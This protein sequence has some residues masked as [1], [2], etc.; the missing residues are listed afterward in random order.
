MIHMKKAFAT[1]MWSLAVVARSYGMLLA[2]AVFVA[3]WAFAAYAWLGLPESSGLLL[4][5]ALIWAIVQL[6]A[7]VVIICGSVSAA[8]EVAA[9]DGRQLPLRLL[10]VKDRAQL[11]RALV[12]FLVCCV[13]VLGLGGIFGWINSHALEVASLLTFHSE[14]PVSYVLIRQIYHVIEGLVWIVLSGFLL[15][16]LMTLLRT[17]RGEARQQAWKLL[18]GSTFRTPF[19]TSLLS[20]AV[21]GGLAYELANWH[22]IVPP[23]FWDYTQV[24]VRWALVLILLATGWSFWLLSLGRLLYPRATPPEATAGL[25]Q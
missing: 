17:G 12:V 19:W 15:S 16:F 5:L 6:G 4:I 11:L 7:A 22:P 21:F 23:G 2:L 24:I 10:W 13:L 1:W 25:F 18:A 20:V 14:K 8:A 9:M 3:L